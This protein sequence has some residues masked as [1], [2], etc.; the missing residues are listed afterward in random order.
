MSANTMAPMTYADA[1]RASAPSKSGVSPPQSPKPSPKAP[2]RPTGTTTSRSNTRKSNQGQKKQKKSKGECQAPKPT[3]TPA[4]P[5]APAPAPAPTPVPVSAS[6]FNGSS[7]A[8]IAASGVPVKKNNGAKPAAK[9]P[10]ASPPSRTAKSK[11]PF[12][13]GAT[14]PT[15]PPLGGPAARPPPQKFVGSP[16]AAALKRGS[17][18]PKKEETPAQQRPSKDQ[19]GV[20]ASFSKGRVV[21]SLGPE[22][23]MVGPFMMPVA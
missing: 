22:E 15:S 14:A 4:H 19:E 16:Y 3:P 23:S 13:N 2:S 10:A 6:S 5:A 9:R 18:A 21:L 20:K 11:K 7:W 1:L 8:Q 17:V 12:G